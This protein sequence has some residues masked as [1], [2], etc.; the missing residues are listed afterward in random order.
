MKHRKLT[1]LAASVALAALALPTLAQ[2]QGVSK[3]QLLIGTILD[4]SGPLAGYGKDLRNGMNLR[5]AEV[6]EQGGV[7]G[8]KLVLRVEDNGYDPKRAVLAAQKLVNQ[9]KVFIMVGMLGA[10]S[11]N[12]AMNTLSQKDIMNFFPMALAKDMYEPVD[13]LK[14][15]FVSSYIEQMTRATPRL[16]KEKNATKACTLYQDDD[17]GQ[18]VMKGA[19]IGL[20]TINVELTERTTYKRGATD[21]SS[22]V[23]R[24]RAANCDFVVLG[25]VIR[26][27]VGAISEA[28]KLGYNPTFLTSVGAYTD[29][30]P[31]LGGKAMDGLYSTMMAQVPY[32]DDTAQPLRFWANKYKTTYNEA[33][34]VFSTYGYVIIDRLVIALQKTGPNVSTD[35]LAKTLESL[36]I[37]S[38]MFGMP[39]M[40]W[41]PTNHLASN[42]ARL[43]QLQNGRWKVVI[44]YDQMKK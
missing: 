2:Q 22:Q 8:R 26:E 12:A 18:E 13:R 9:D 36:T 17:Y 30:I 3:D 25:T 14:F 42:E 37:P 31:R 4:L 40:S 15:A 41:S 24:L 44:D 21:F 6:N 10:A 34:T 28:Q 35:A 43:S 27:T 32:E 29:L 11:A 7:H 39:A 16:F 1:R 23:A 5:I 19:E 38:D 20:K 33:P